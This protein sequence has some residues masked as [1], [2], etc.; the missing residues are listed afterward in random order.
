MKN[1]D[2]RSTKTLKLFLASIKRWSKLAF[3]LL[4]FTLPVKKKKISSS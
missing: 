4:C 3:K 2:F 1:F